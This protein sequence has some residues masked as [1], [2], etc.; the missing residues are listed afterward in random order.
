MKKK[1]LIFA[2]LCLLIALLYIE[3]NEE[4]FIQELLQIEKEVDREEELAEETINVVEEE[5]EVVQE[6]ELQLADSER[7]L[8][9]SEEKT[10]ERFGEPNRKDVSAYGY[11]WWIYLY[12]EQTNTYLQIGIENGAVVTAFFSGGVN[13]EMFSLGDTYDSINKALPFQQLVDVK[14]EKG[15]YQFE[16][17][18]EDLKMRPVIEIENAWVQLYFDI[19]T[20]QLSSV[21]M[22]TAEVF[23]SQRPYSVSY[24]GE[25][26]KRP[27][28]TEEQWTLVENGE[29][30]QIFDYTNI[31]R[32][33]HNLEAFLWEEDVSNVAYQH[34]K[35]MST[36]NY[37][38]HTSPTFGEVADRFSSA[39]IPYRL[40][41]E[42]IAAKYADGIAAVEGWL[43]SEGHRVNLLHDEFTHLGVG[44]YQDYFTQNFYTPWPL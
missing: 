8:G 33:R 44:V 29:A 26:P 34:S 42:N 37:F 27:Q 17:S 30:K 15:D 22:M 24:I 21:R 23:V 3:S 36:N 28:L 35:D 1:Y 43:N 39:D 6:N 14:T 5:P 38:S 7:L 11:E 16:L 41:G 20:K 13:G 40:A 18:E 19:H 31:I 25:A 4:H 10:I 9:L 32:E 2:A 12:P